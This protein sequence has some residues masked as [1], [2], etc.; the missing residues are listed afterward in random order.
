MSGEHV[1]ICVAWPYA[2]GPLH[3]GHVAGC[4]L[5]PDIHARYERAK[6]NR[7]LMVSGSDEHG[8]RLLLQLKLWE[9]LHKMLLTN[10]TL[11]T[12]RPFLISAV[13]GSQISTLVELIMVVLYS[14]EQVTRNTRNSYR[15][16]SN[17]C[18]KRDYLSKKQCNNITRFV[19]MV[20]VS[21]LIVMS[22]VNAQTV[23]K[24]GLEVINVMNV[25]RPTNLMNYK[26]HV[27]K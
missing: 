17:H 24:M 6:G 16:I 1:L 15:T 20:A 3:L 21:S 14:T 10:T 25:V 7:V 13:H 8:T 22:K 11:P 4:Y 26:I 5:P 9:Y 19:K 2:N 18:W 12:L 23:V 27:Q